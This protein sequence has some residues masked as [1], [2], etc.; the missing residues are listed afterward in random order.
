[1]GNKRWPQ[2]DVFANRVKEF[3]KKNNGLLTSR[4][5]VK[6]DIVADMFNIHEDTLRQL[7]TDTTRMR[8]HLNTLSFISSI[9][10]CSVFEFLDAPHDP[11]PAISL[12][13]WEGLTERERALV[14]TL[15]TEISSGDLSVDEKTEL[16][17]DFQQTKA[18]MLRLKGMWTASAS[19][20]SS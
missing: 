9:I 10:G 5:A 18:R 11:P 4:G 8:P 16:C 12:E 1:M 3:C 14:V 17:E 13:R 6:I 15:V 19:N 2:Q 20:T 7:L